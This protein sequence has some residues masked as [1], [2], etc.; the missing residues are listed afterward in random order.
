MSANPFQRFLETQGFVVLDGGLA[1]ALEDAGYVLDSDLW[2][3]R[4]LVDAPSAVRAVHTAYLAAGADCVTSAGYQAS[5]DGFQALGF[6]VRDAAALV[7]EAV[8]LALEAKDD[9]WSRPAN[10]EG[11]L[12][13]IVAA[14][15]GPYGA[16]LADGS[17]YD[18]RYYGVARD[19][20]EDFHRS[21]LTILADAGADLIAFE[22]IPSMEEACL[23]SRL[24]SEVPDTWAWITFSCRDGEHLWDGTRIADA[25][26]AC[27]TGAR[28]AGV[29]INCTAPRFVR[30]LVHEVRAVT[31]LPVVVYPNS[32]ETYDVG[33]KTWR[34]QPAGRKWLGYLPGWVEAGARVVGGCCRVGPGVVRDLRQG[35]TRLL[36]PAG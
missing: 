33:A 34:G 36:S 6:G 24:L 26:R 9:F 3:A 29:G 7:R 25:V 31:E 17:E 21:R 30:S 10:R 20:L 18:G 2:S 22:T 14:S 16:F 8:R 13:P 27:R 19:V 4:A 15:A 23:I 12:E 5:L 32:G 28:L 1:T 11:R 35:L